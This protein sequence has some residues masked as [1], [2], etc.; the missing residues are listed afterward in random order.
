MGG[1]GVLL[2]DEEEVRQRPH[3][4][5]RDDTTSKGLDQMHRPEHA[6]AGRRGGEHGIQVGGASCVSLHLA[7]LRSPTNR[8]AIRTIVPLLDPKCHVDKTDEDGHLHQRPYH[9]GESLD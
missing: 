1:G 9:G 7:G 5:H 6:R 3:E 8:D 2:L 4:P